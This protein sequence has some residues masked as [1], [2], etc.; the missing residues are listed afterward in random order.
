MN[1]FV[2]G[3]LVG[4]GIGLLVAPM[5]GEEMRRIVRERFKE[6]RTNL[7]ENE[8]LNRYVQQVSDRVSQTGSMLKVYAQ[9]AAAKMQSTASDLKG[10]AQQAG[11]EVKQTGRDVAGTTKEAATKAR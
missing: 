3:M 9:Q 8:E 10:L 1:S 4:T 11:S 7:P 2:K 6:L 5:K